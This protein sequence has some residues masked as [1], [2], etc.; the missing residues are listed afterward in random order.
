MRQAGRIFTGI[1]A[2]ETSVSGFIELAQTPDLAG[3]GNH[4]SRFDLLGVDA[5]IIFSD[6]LVI[7][8]LWDCLK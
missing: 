7:R 8:K 1:P 4:Y 3:G 6:I 5:A 2:V